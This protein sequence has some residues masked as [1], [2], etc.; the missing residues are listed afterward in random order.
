M[1]YTCLPT[2]YLFIIV[3]SRSHEAPYYVIFFQGNRENYTIINVRD[4]FLN[5]LIIKTNSK[6]RNLLINVVITKHPA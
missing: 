4:Y 5:D 6:T 1:R 3:K 2:L